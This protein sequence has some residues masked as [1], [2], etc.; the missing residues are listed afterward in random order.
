MIRLWSRVRGGGVCNLSNLLVRV[1]I[2]CALLCLELIQVK[3]WL[4][5]GV[6]YN[7]SSGVLSR[8]SFF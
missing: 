1:I 3:K 7:K 5:Q 6:V 8:R 4:F 2:C